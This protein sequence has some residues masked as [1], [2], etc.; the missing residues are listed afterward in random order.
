V[1]TIRNALILSAWSSHNDSATAAQMRQAAI[2]LF[3][4]EMFDAAIEKENK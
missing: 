4:Q 1:Q 3:G 2:L